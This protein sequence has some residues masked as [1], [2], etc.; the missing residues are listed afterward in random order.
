M[1]FV[2]EFPDRSGRHCV[3]FV[4]YSLQRGFIRLPLIPPLP[5]DPDTS[6]IHRQTTEPRA[7]RQF[8]EKG[9][10]KNAE[11]KSLIATCINRHRARTTGGWEKEKG[12]KKRKKKNRKGRWN[13]KMNE[14]NPR[15]RKPASSNSSARP[16]KRPFG[17]PFFSFLSFFF[18][19][20]SFLF[21]FLFGPRSVWIS[22]YMWKVDRCSRVA[23]ESLARSFASI[24]EALAG[25]PSPISVQ[26]QLAT[27][28]TSNNIL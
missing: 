21:P 24:E 22:V 28:S 20:F 25:A 15:A 19:F 5:Y 18:L 11:T 23:F 2:R 4:F 14:R 12:K 8:P 13:K 16:S 27:A 7:L 26:S 9:K 6:F 1:I 3:R 10:G 17:F